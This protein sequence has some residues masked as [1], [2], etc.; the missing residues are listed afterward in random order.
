MPEITFADVAAMDAGDPLAHVRERFAIADQ[1]IYL[2]GNSLGALPR[3]TF[4]RVQECIVQ[5]WGSDLI[6]SWNTHDW[7]GLPKRIGGKIANLIGAR[8]DEVIVCD[9]TSIN[10]F[11]LINAALARADPAKKVLT[12][13]R[14]FPTNRYMLDSIG[15]ERVVAV[16][17]DDLLSRLDETVALLALTHVDYRSGE[18][19]DMGQVTEAAH[20]VGALV[21]W[22]LSHSAGAVPLNLQGS[23]ADLA[24]GCGYKYLNGGPGAPAYLYVKRAL[25]AELQ[26]PLPGWLGHADPFAFSQD[27]KGGAGIERFLCGTPPILSMAALECGIDQFAALDTDALYAKGRELCELY[28]ALMEQ[29]CAGCDFKLVSP[30]DAARRGCH[31][32][33]SHPHAYAVC[34]ALI[35]RKVIGDFRTPDVFRAGFA[36]MYTRF[37]DVWRAVEHIRDVMQTGAWNQEAFRS[38]NRVT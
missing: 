26:T 5:Q 23:D 27:Y 18:M 29:T 1:T 15:H 21:L 32:S 4:A 33:Y 7:I 20:R 17:R 9:S 3:E 22:D 31:V 25:Q 16:A 11:K 30:R 35:A 37:V 19:L 34:Q 2:D 10:F 13:D 6:Q 14:G 24:V 38:R 8:D 12:E 36:P 28:I